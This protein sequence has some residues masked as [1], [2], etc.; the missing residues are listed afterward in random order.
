MALYAFDGT[1]NKERADDPT[2][3]NTNVSRF[4]HAYRKQSGTRDVYEQGIGTK[5]GVLGK[6]IGG[7]FGAGELDRLLDAYRT[8]CENWAAGDR[9]VDLVGFSRGAATC[10]DFCNLVQQ[11]DIKDPKALGSDWRLDDYLGAPKIAK[12]PQIHLIGLFDVVGA[13]GLG[14]AG[15]IK[16]L[17][18]GH[19][20]S[21]PN[22]RVSYC[23]HA[24][25]L[26]ETRVSFNVI[27]LKG[28]HEVWFRG[29]HSDV[30]GGDGRRGLNDIALRWMFRKAKGAGI[31]IADEDIAALQPNPLCELKLHDVPEVWRPM[32]QT[33]LRHYT[34]TPRPDCRP[35]ANGCLIE[36]EAAEAVAQPIGS[37]GI[38]ADLSPT[39]A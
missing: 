36:D 9:I 6:A 22:N 10:L 29:V 24:M 11:W 26:D 12:D 31:K 38:E 32:S 5:L 28:A 3:E 25:A 35:L 13:F 34:A 8:L 23:F 33:D 14:V 30:G 7:A 4:Y 39:A 19:H 2:Y 37:N 15:D 20:L 16:I 18:I 1:W 21:L 27:R 17:N